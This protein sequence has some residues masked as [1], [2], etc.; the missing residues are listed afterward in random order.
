MLLLR[1]SPKSGLWF[2]ILLLGFADCRL[3]FLKKQESYRRVVSSVLCQYQ[4]QCSNSERE[5]PNVLKKDGR[6]TSRVPARSK[7]DA[8]LSKSSSDDDDSIDN[9]KWTLDLDWLTK[10]FE[11][12]HQY[13]SWALPTGLFIF[14]GVT[15]IRV[16]HC[17]DIN[18]EAYKGPTERPLIS[19][20]QKI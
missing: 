18:V 16:W 17:F 4:S 10:A 15:W 5:E 8:S 1:W 6:D 3:N 14:S 20:W 2:S 9:N 11:P 12:A 7:V 19:I 13:F